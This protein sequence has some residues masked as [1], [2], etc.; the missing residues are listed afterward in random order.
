MLLSREENGAGGKSDTPPE[1]WFADKDDAYLGM[2][3][4]PKD[5]ALWKLERFE[6]FVAERKKLIQDKFSAFLVQQRAAT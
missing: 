1:K 5:P 4:I 6:D 2:H 3:L